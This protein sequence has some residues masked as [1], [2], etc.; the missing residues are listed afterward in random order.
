VAKNQSGDYVIGHRLRVPELSSN[1]VKASQSSGTGRQRRLSLS[2][3]PRHT[4]QMPALEL[5]GKA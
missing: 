5:E 3:G 1:A 2:D 4:G